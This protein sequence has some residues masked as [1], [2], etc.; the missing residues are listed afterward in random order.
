MQLLKTIA[1]CL[2]IDDWQKGYMS[3]TNTEKPEVSMWR[4]CEFMNQQKEETACRLV[5]LMKVIWLGD[6]YEDTEDNTSI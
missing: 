1:S 5:L 4:S 6:K 2:Q 3:A